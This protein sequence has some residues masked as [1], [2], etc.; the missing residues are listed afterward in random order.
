MQKPKDT[1]VSSA[2]ETDFIKSL[3]AKAGGTTIDIYRERHPTK[4]SFLEFV[5]KLS[6]PKAFETWV[7]KQ[8]I[9]KL[10]HRRKNDPKEKIRLRTVVYKG[11]PERSY[12]H[13]LDELTRLEKA[14]EGR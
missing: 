3:V 11:P 14:L 10:F 2:S 12:M 5:F 4:G 6:S 13:L 7:Q 1:S 8:C 9:T